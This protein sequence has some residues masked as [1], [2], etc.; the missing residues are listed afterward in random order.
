MAYFQ[1]ITELLND[2]PFILSDFVLPQLET[3]ITS[4]PIDGSLVNVCKGQHIISRVPP[5]SD[6]ARHHSDG[7]VVL[8]PLFGTG[9]LFEDRFPLW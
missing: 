1:C 5:C 9:K 4:Q 2:H 6:V 3:A 8:L 7:D